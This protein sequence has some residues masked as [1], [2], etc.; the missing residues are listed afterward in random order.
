MCCQLVVRRRVRARRPRRALDQPRR[1]RANHSGGEVEAGLATADQLE[2]DGG[3]Q[4]AIELGAVLGALAE[5]DAE[6]PA[7]RVKAELRAGKAALRQQQRVLDLAGQR[8]AAQ[9]LELGTEKFQVEFG[10]MDDQ[11]VAAD[12]GEQLVDYRGERRM[13]RQELGGEAV[14]FF[15][16][17]RD[18]ALRIDIAMEGAPGRQM[19]EQLDA[20][21]LDDAVSLRRLEPGGFRIKDD[22]AHAVQCAARESTAQA[23]SRRS[24]RTICLSLRWVRARPR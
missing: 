3:E 18:V 6:A 20:G 15:R 9:P 16:F 10:I 22:L 8:G 4:L 11:A 23:A 12:E 2:I 19:V 24:S 17:G 21:D 7:E 5:I 14:H 13:L 1:L